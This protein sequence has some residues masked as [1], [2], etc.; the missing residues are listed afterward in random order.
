MGR[1]PNVRRRVGHIEARR[2]RAIIARVRSFPLKKADSGR[3]ES[4]LN[5]ALNNWV[6]TIEPDWTTN[7][8]IK[9]PFAG[10]NFNPDGTL[11]GGPGRPPLIAYEGKRLVD[12]NPQKAWKEGI[13]QAFTYRELFKVA[14]LV[15]YDF[16]TGSTYA[17]ALGRGNSTES[18]FASKIRKKWRIHIVVITPT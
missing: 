6:A 5:L 15:L 7:Q 13:G 1:K 17:R 3:P 12:A 2:L 9:I 8:H 14:V 10:A 18:T 11:A 4:D 16:T